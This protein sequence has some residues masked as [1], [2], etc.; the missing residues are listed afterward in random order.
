MGNFEKFRWDKVEGEEELLIRAMLYDDPI[1]VFKS[2]PRDKLKEIFLEKLHRFDKKNINFWK[3]TLGIT[4]E[5]I[6]EYAEKNFRMGGK[7]FRP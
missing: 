1:E 4:D 7:I 6:R 3:I 2:V 5:Q